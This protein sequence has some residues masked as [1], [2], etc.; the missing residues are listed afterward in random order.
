MEKIKKHKSVFK[1]ETY[2]VLTIFQEDLEEI[3]DIFKSNFSTVD[4]EIDEYKIN[5]A[6]EINEIK[7]EKTNYFYI[8]SQEDGPVTLK[9]SKKGNEISIPDKDNAKLLGVFHKLEVIL[10]K[11]KSFIF[12]ILLSDWMFYMFPIAI[13]VSCI[14]MFWFSQKFM[15]FFGIAIGLAFLYIIYIAS[16][17]YFMFR[18]S[19]NIYLYYSDSKIGFFGRNKDKIISNL[20]SGIGGGLIVGI[21]L[22][23]FLGK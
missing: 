12:N 13:I 7:K 4:I 9:L 6:S 15:L 1:R 17:F 10:N 21:I 8:K 5:D 11:R 22:F 3:I 14:S 16:M 2:H 19:V 18:R 20:I 23:L